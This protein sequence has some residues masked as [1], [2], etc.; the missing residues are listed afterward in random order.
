MFSKQN[1]H[2]QLVSIQLLFYQT[3]LIKFFD[4]QLKIFLIHH[5][6]YKLLYQ[7]QKF[8]LIT[9]LSFFQV[10]LFIVYLCKLYQLQV[11]EV[12]KKVNEPQL[13]YQT[14]KSRSYYNLSLNNLISYYLIVQTIYHCQ[15]FQCL[16]VF[17]LMIS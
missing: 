7:F 2:R 13:K 11:N 8:Y 6:Y 4:K 3:Q 10:F 15:N 1:Q 16:V 14:I 9:R 5:L 17:F 12:L